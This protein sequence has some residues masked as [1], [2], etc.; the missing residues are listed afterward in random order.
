V[1]L[2]PQ[3]RE[4]L[5]KA[6]LG[7]TLKEAENVLARALVTRG[8]LDAEAVKVIL[9]EKKQLIRKSGILEYFEHEEGLENLGGMEILKD[10]LMKR[11]TAFSEK[12]HQ[13]GLPSPRGILLLGVQGCGKSLAAKTVSALWRQPLLR[14][15]MGSIFSGLVG[16]SEENIRRAIKTA[17]SIAPAVLWVDEIEK[18]FSGTQS[19]GASDGGTTSRV[20]ATFLTWLQEKSKPVFVIATANNITQLPA[21]LLRKGRLDEIFFVDLPDAQER[22][23]IFRIHIAKKGRDP[24][25]YDIPSLSAASEGFSG[26]EIEQAVISALYDAYDANRELAFQDLQQAL[27][28]TVPLSRTMSE[29][30][31]AMRLWAGPRARRASR[32]VEP[33]P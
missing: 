33:C 9:S 24:V 32:G 10:W 6:A 25:L 27:L 4:K 8:A 28:V 31:E 15:D 19:S 11:S 14:L 2:D 17:E 20:F 30:I 7:L 13:F 18:A 16:S 12:A 26:S 1:E 5:V 23:Q 21:E 22:E 29:P 3:A